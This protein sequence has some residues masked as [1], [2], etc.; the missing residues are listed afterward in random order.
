MKRFGLAALGG[1]AAIV[2]GLLWAKPHGRAPLPPRLS[3]VPVQLIADGYDTAVL[4]IDAPSPTMPRVTIEPAHVATVTELSAADHGFQAR[5]RAGVTPAAITVRVEIPGRPE[6]VV[7]LL[8]KLDATDSAADG[9][10]DFLR[11]DDPDDRQAFS[12]WFTFLAET[13]YFEA[14]ER[15]PIEIV[16]C[17]A[18][19]R[20]AYREA[21]RAHDGNWATEARLPLVP[22]ISSTTKYQ[23]P[24]TPLG[25]DLFRVKSG[26]FQPADLTTGGFAQFADAKTLQL[27]N[28]HFVTRDLN[29]AQPGDLLFYR[30]DNEHMA[31]HSMICLGPSQIAKGADR[32]L[33]YHT[34]PDAESPGE[35]R[36]PTLDELL[37]FPDPDWRPLPDNPRFLGVYRWNILRKT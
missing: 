37:H 33:V 26:G 11:L 13:Q 34:G 8:T 17:A 3:L 9:T 7:R 28:T 35:I 16:D 25:A 19:I 32:Y 1:A 2:V 14:A 29:R 18:L 24:Y 27:R 12:R 10:P 22:G 4:T 6:A 31:F 30:Q 21:L 23:Y 15:R 36:R 5:I 20:Y